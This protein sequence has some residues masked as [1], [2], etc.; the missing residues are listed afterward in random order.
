MFKAMQ[1]GLF[2]RVI[3]LLGMLLL[4]NGCG[5]SEPNKPT[6]P[7]VRPAKIFHVVAPNAEMFRHF[8]AEVAANADSQLA[9]RVSGQITTFP[10]KPGN[11]V[12][13]GQL[14]ASLDKTD[15]Q[16]RLDD[17]TARYELA[18]SQFERA[19][20]L[21]AQ[22]L[23][24]QSAYDEAKANLSVAH[25]ALGS[26]ET[27]LTYTELRAPFDGTV[28]K[29]MVKKHENIVAKQPV[30]M[31]QTRDLIDISIQIPENI[32]SK[33]HKESSYQPTVVFD[34]HP[35]QQFLVSI[36][37]WDTQAD[38]TTLT[39]KVVFSLPTPTSFNVLPGMSAKV[40][41]DL[42]KITEVN[43]DILL[44]PVEAVFAAEDVP[45]AQ[46]QRFVWLLEPSTMTVSKVSITVGEIKNQGIE[47]LSGLTPGQKIIAAGVHYLTDG[48]KVRAWTREKG[49]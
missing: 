16:L 24:P 21:L 13:K 42:A 44:I 46:Q 40:S 5:Q 45:L 1:D 3:K 47:V 31:L 48:M 26:A 25:S 38:P 41:I 28:A 36:K 4:L 29:V 34:S 15:F 7:I 8:P 30:L 22:K 43:K 12:S 11:M 39:Y 20:S 19:K 23:A 18:Q 37:Q 10:V 32:I 33:V 14:L 49:L 27:D 2:T 17:R 35:E 9:F 6:E